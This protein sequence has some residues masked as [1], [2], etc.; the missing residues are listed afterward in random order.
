MVELTKTRTVRLEDVAH[1]NP[2]LSEKIDPST[3]VSFVGMA[4]LSADRAATETED[5][6]PYGEVAKGYTAFQNGDLLLAKITPCF[7]NGKIG[8]ARLS[9]RLGFGSTE[10]HVIRP[11][12]ELAESRFLLHF[13][14]SP[15]FRAAG[16]MRMTGSGGQRR[17]PVDYVKQAQVYLPPL[18]EQRRI[19]AI[20]DKADELRTKR[21]RAIGRLDVLAQSIFYSMFGDPARNPHQFPKRQLVDLCAA[22]DDIRC[23]PFGTQLNKDEFR[24]TGVPLWGI[25]NVNKSF[26]LPTHEFLEPATAERLDSYSVLPGDIVMTRKGTVGNCSVYP[27]NFPR[28]IMHSDLLRLRLDQNIANV[29]FISD[30]LH[31]SRDVSHQVSLISG[32]AIM[33]G[34]NVSKLK[35]IKVL[36]PPLADQNEYATRVSAV[37]GLKDR[38]RVQLAQLDALCASL[39]HRAFKGELR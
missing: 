37:D 5:A 3:F 9:H 34:I 13:L 15:K 1:V 28:G 18:G 14:R 38:Y 39:Q 36:A 24:S 25:K 31:S 32:G 8:Q 23:G 20:L 6:L 17:V 30:Q 10:F 11:R 19:A 7:E 12:P 35:T 29:R 33:A 16:E 2:R 26:K 21:L 27:E 4:G 22:P